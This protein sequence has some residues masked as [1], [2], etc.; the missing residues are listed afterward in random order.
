VLV[1]AVVVVVLLGERV[2][3]GMR[4]G[5]VHDLP[6]VPGA[7]LEVRKVV[8]WGGATLKDGY[9]TSPFV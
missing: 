5:H 4:G 6:T 8:E 3:F 1:E 9:K 2:G 7:D